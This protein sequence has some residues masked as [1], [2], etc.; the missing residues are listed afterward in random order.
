[1]KRGSLYRKMGD[2]M[3]YFY[4]ISGGTIV[5]EGERGEIALCRGVLCKNKEGICMFKKEKC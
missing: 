2:A 3:N 1:M 5:K 4:S